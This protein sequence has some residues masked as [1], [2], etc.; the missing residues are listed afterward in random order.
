MKENFD[1]LEFDFILL[2]LTKLG[3]APNVLY[4]DD[5]NF[6]VSGSGMQ[7]VGEGTVSL[8]A[9][10]EPEHWKETPREALRYYMKDV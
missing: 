8:M 6:A 9:I 1:E 5:G 3:D 4:D 7:S 10:V 2:E